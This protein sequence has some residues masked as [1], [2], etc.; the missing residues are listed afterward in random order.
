MNVALWVIAGGAL[1]WVAFKFMDK[2]QARGL[3][4]SVVIGAVGGFAGGTLLAPLFGSAVAVADAS[5]FR[6]FALAVAC[7]SAFACV[8]ISD[9]V[10]E[11][12]GM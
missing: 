9:M 2:N 11:R 6:P 3:I 8:T 12:Y 5:D 10:Y 7:A 1:G 4:I